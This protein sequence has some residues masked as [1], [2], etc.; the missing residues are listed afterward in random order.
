MAVPIKT[1]VLL[2]H[3]DAIAPIYQTV[4]GGTEKGQRIR[5][6]K[7]PR[8][9][10]PLQVTFTDETGKNVTIR[11]KANANTI[12]QDEQIK[13]G[14]LANEKFST[15]EYRDPEFKQ[16]ILVAMKPMLQTFLEANPSSKGS[17]ECAMMCSG[18]LTA[19]WIVEMKRRSP[20]RT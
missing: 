20:T 5:I 10:P 16:G 1:Y 6:T 7:I 19:C 4:K 9:R 13:L 8:H 14:I 11:Y 15:T 17:R 3:M 12:F 2:E 18:L